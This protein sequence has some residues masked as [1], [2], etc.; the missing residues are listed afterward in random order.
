MPKE[1][2]NVDN[3]CGTVAVTL[4]IIS[5]VIPMCTLLAFF[6]PFVGF[7]LSVTAFFFAL[8]QGRTSA[9]KWSKAGIILAVIGFVMNGVILL[10][11]LSILASI[12]DKYQELC[13]LAGSCDNIPA[14]FAEQ[15]AQQLATQYGVGA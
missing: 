13:T 4:G 2:V 14:Y 3:S 9:N 15:K 12:G 7:T 10:I 8:A 11:M 5:I 1:S 6:A